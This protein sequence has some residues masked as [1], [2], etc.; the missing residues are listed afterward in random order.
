MGKLVVE[1]E[2]VV[3]ETNGGRWRQRLKTKMA[4]MFNSLGA[5]HVPNTL[6]LV[7]GC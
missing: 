2:G 3:K 7:A 5:G 4:I 6:Y 1:E